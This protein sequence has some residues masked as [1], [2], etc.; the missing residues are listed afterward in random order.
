MS[1]AP[2]AKNVVAEKLVMEVGA[3]EWGA[4]CQVVLCVEK[5]CRF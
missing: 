2:C 5:G 4:L 1:R 3:H